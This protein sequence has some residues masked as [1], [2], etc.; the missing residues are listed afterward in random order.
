MLQEKFTQAKDAE[1]S[2]AE[3]EEKVKLERKEYLILF[4]LNLQNEGDFILEL[5]SFVYF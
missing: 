5:L 4:N 2:H 1:R 3:A